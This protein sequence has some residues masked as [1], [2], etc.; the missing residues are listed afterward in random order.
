MHVFDFH[1]RLRGVVGAPVRIMS[2]DVIPEMF[3]QPDDK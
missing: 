3:M 1:L 2:Q